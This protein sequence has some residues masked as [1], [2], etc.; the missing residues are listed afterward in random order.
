V[1]A[2]L[3]A[4]AVTEPMHAQV[5]VNIQ[6]W[7]FAGDGWYVGHTWN[8]PWAGVAP[9]HVPIP[10]LRVPVRYYRVPPSHW[11][12]GRRDAPP[13]WEAHYGL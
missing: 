4:L 8:G 2:A 3:L 1:L 12:G 5:S 7:L 6:Y 13:Q 10:I 9:A 11:K